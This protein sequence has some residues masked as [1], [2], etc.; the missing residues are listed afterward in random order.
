MTPFLRTKNPSAPVG[1]TPA[2]DERPA[3][4]R[5]RPLLRSLCSPLSDQTPAASVSSA[6]AR[7][8]ELPVFPSQG[9]GAPE[10]VELLPA[11]PEVM[12]RDGRR[13]VFDDPER[14]AAASLDESDPNLSSAKKEIPIDWEHATEIKAP[15]GEPAPAAG[16]I[17]ALEVRGSSSQ[18]ALWGRVE[19]TERGREAVASRE[20]R[21]LSPVFLHEKEPGGRIVRLLS[22]G[23]TNSP[24][25]RMTALNQL[26]PPKGDGDTMDIKEIFEALGLS[27]D[28]TAEQAAAAVNALKQE[29]DTA[30]NRAKEK[31][32]SS[33]A[34][35]GLDKF[36]PRADY[37]AA[38]ERAT[39][40]ETKLAEH[41]AQALEKE[42]EAEITKALEAG[43]ITPATADYHRA[44]C[45]VGSEEKN[46]EKSG[47]ERFREY[48]EAAP[49]IAGD[50]GL[51]GKQP[52]DAKDRALNADL[53]SSQSRIAA[54]FGNSAGPA[55]VRR[56]P[57]IDANRHE[58]GEKPWLY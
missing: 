49:A 35:P 25:L 33:A 28:A 58:G 6:A 41:E 36:V 50:S 48:V 26:F 22:A 21:Y 55:E 8:V 2:G 20:Y 4:G 42:I 30:L 32:D 38:L 18:G 43:K 5:G 34:A 39:N 45:R 11:G 1:V 27:G 10:W 13:W 40:A 56:G 29:R 23:L 19:W 7:C 12:G 51:D 37:D 3:G 54:L 52:K 46:G 47:L 17:T 14:V 15:Q 24:N 16:W 9:G 57:R 44:Q 31:V 53:S